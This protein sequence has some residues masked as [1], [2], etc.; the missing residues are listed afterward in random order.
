MT[1]YEQRKLESMKTLHISAGGRGERMASYISSIRPFLPKHLLPIPTEGK[2]IL[3]DIIFQALGDF[4]EI[5]VWASKETYP[6]ISFGLEKTVS[7]GVSVDAK[8]TGPLGPLM[9]NLIRNKVRTFGC[10]GDF[11]CQFSWNEFEKFHNSHGLPI[12]ILIAKSIPSPKGAK[13]NLGEH[14]LINSWERV[15]KT[16]KE[17]RINI[18][19]YIID[20]TP[21]VLAMATEIVEHKEDHFFD[22]FISKKMVGGYDPEKIAFNVNVPEVYESLLHAL[23]S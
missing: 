5:R 7:V 20:P 16:S 1:K 17:D 11:Y 22:M 23:A 13:F 10:A 12:S 3:G 19:C 21:E 6:R 2:T 4:E 9:R 15:D 14:G 8:M 18:G